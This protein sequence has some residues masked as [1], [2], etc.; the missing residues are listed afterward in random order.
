MANQSAPGKSYRKGITLL[1]VVNRF[2]DPE[3]AEQWFVEQRWPDGVTCPA[4]ASDAVSERKNRR[5]AP[6]HCRSCRK[7]FSVKTGTLCTTPSCP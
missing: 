7:T 1:D 5:P 3:Q 2:G 4:C 6:Y